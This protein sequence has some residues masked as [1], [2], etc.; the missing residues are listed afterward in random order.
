M[1]TIREEAGGGSRPTQ[2]FR[3]CLGFSHIFPLFGPLLALPLV[4]HTILSHG[5][6]AH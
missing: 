4:P 6:P 2:M 1:E 5:T 3:A